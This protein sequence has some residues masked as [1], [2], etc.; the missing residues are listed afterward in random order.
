M[1]NPINL[2]SRELRVGIGS[3]LQ[4]VDLTVGNTVS[5]LN[6]NA[7]GKYIGNAGIATGTL[8]ITTI[9]V[10]YT[11]SSGTQQY[12]GVPLTNITGTGFNALAD[13]TISN[14]VA[15]AATISSFNA[16]SG[17]TGYV[18][19]DVLGI[20]TIGAQN[21]GTGVRMSVVS[22]A[23][24][25]E[26]IL[27]NVQ[28]DFVTG[29]GNTV[30][31]TN[32]AG[33]TTDMNAAS[34][35][36]V[37]ITALNTVNDGLHFQVNHKNHGMYWSNNYV[38]LSDV[39]SD[40]IPTTLTTAYTST[41][42]DSITVDSESGFGTFENVGVGT[43][44]AG[45]VLIGDEVISYTSTSTGTLNGTIT[46]SIDSTTA[47]NYPAGT[48]V[49]KY[50]VGGVSLRRINKTHNLNNVT[51]AN[52]LTFDSYNV[53]LDMGASGVGRSTAESFPI[54]YTGETKSAG[55]YEVTATQNIPF[56]II[57]PTVQTLTV[58]GTSLSSQVRTVSATGISGSEIPWQDQGF[59]NVSLNMS[60]YLTTP[61]TVASN[62]NATNN[63]SN[64]P[65]DKSINL[66][67]D[68]DTVD[69]KVSPVIDTS[70]VSTILTS[71]RVNDVVTN[72][73]TDS[74]VDT[75][76]EDP[77]AFQY[78]SKAIRL[79]NPATGLKIIVDA[80]NNL[81]SN[82]RAFYA[83][84]DSEDFNPIYVPFPGYNNLDERGQIINPADSDGLSDK[85]VSPS[86]TAGFSP[87]AVKF[88]EHTFTIDELSSFRAYRIKIVMTST[89]QAYVP[90][91]RDLRVIALA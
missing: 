42:T 60:N 66:R 39:E 14:G 24:T 28:G 31:F 15:V 59:E 75:V 51:I 70:R 58:P 26:I 55:G 13:V 18:V 71:N 64:L 87:M 29:A 4:D 33:L 88:N 7:T 10:G 27:D 11:P 73:A 68:L 46:R 5:Q 6:S 19:G 38:T 17:G 69:T 35:G 83:T 21:L 84:G 52:P 3:T 45:Y 53:K 22:I 47:K 34:G 2:T 81:D 62:I 78:L 79:E 12:N 63:L 72:F 20:T 37:L 1:P 49:Y 54:L 16:D 86:S 90:R 9:G 50:E 48:P 65:G 43:T 76:S 67:I 44:N 74:R 80:Y 41:Q 89:N 23:N 85:Y 40:S 77:T 36:N 57:T 61:R 8:N 82:I 91:I 56:E 32:N 25:N 30:Q